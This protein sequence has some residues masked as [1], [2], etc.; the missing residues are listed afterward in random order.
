MLTESFDTILTKLIYRV[1][2]RDSFGSDDDRLGVIHTCL[3]L[4]LDEREH[5]LSEFFFKNR[6]LII[7]DTMLLFINLWAFIQVFIKNIY[8]KNG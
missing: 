2:E 1:I 3:N 5:G 8:V 4:K 6:E 7:Q